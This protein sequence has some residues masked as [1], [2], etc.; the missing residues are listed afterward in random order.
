[1]DIAVFRP[2]DT[3]Q[4]LAA[5]PRPQ[6]LAP[7][8]AVVLFTLIVQRLTLPA[9]VLRL[10]QPIEGGRG[11]LIGELFI[12]AGLFTRGRVRVKAGNIGCQKAQSTEQKTQKEIPCV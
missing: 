1:M 4:K 2:G 9:V 5:S 3:P 12:R 11:D 10:A 6:T 8:Y 7:A